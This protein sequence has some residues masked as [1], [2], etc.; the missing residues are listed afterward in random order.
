M[1]VVVTGAIGFVGSHAVEHFD[2]RGD[3]VV[4]LDNLSRGAMLGKDYGE[5]EGSWAALQARCPRVKL[6]RGDVREPTAILEAARGANAIV[7]TAGQVAVTS[8]VADPV[9]DFDT[10]VRGTFH[11][12]E[13]ARQNDCAVVFCSTNKVYGSNVNS[14]R[15]RELAD[16]YVFA[17]PAFERGIPESFPID[18]TDHS[19]YGCSKLAADL[20]VQ[21]YA[22]TYGLKTGVFRMSCIYGERQ[23]GIEDQGWVAWFTIASVL[24]LPLTIYGDGKQ[25]R[26]VLHVDDLVRAYA[27]FLASPIRSAVFNTGGGPGHTLSLLGLVELLRAAGHPPKSVAYAGWRPADQKVYV[28]DIRRLERDLSWTPSIPPAEGV[29]RLLAWVVEN[30]S[31]F[32]HLAPRPTTGSG[33]KRRASRPQ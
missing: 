21:E 10:N 11:I 32:A 7:H 33:P 31:L 29:R 22:Y 2:R 26:D 23:F 6:S 24:G 9:T 3:E 19:P 8:S 17:D 28:T 5:L 16:R 4:G 15:V 14:I 1:K 27:A 13:A 20:Y 25:V 12:L 18:G 30:R